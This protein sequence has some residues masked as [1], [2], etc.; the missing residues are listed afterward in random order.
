MVEVDY[1]ARRAEADLV[2]LRSDV[3]RAQAHERELAQPLADSFDERLAETCREFP[4][5][6]PAEVRRGMQ[7]LD[8]WTVMRM[9]QIACLAPLGHLSSVR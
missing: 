2:I 7:Q 3:W 6:P 5:V 9:G 4:E 8:A 1:E